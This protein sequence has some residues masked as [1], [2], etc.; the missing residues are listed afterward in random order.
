MQ[1]THATNTSAGQETAA[2]NLAAFNQ[3]FV[4][5]DAGDDSFTGRNVATSDTDATIARTPSCTVTLSTPVGTLTISPTNSQPPPIIPVPECS[6]PDCQPAI[7][8]NAKDIPD[9]TRTGVR[10]SLCRTN[11][12]RPRVAYP[13]LTFIKPINS[14]GMLGDPPYPVRPLAPPDA[15]NK[16]LNHKEPHCRA[17]NSRTYPAPLAP[18]F[19]LKASSFQAPFRSPTPTDRPPTPLAM[20]S[21]LASAQLT[22]L[23]SA[24]AAILL[25]LLP[26]L[27]TSQG[28]VDYPVCSL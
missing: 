6:I 17:K 23:T 9:D 4:D 7:P 5:I 24:A 20:Q 11:K 25:Q 28:H 26:L 10:T 19:G 16:K 18:G 15:L 1:T 13:K 8:N 12:R 22:S 27:Q 2:I 3:S 21:G 14:I